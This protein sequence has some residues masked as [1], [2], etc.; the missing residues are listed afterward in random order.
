MSY[1]KI[2]LS[3]LIAFFSIS[4]AAHAATEWQAPTPEELS[5]KSEP[6]A[7]GA[8]AIYLDRDAV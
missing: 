1:P 3:L 5:M 8:I 2:C 4:L 6:K 7:P